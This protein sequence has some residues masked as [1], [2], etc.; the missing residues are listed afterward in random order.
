MSEYNSSGEVTITAEQIIQRHT[1]LALIKSAEQQRIANVI[2]VARLEIEHPSAAARLSAADI[3]YALE[4]RVALSA[5]EFVT[6]VMDSVDAIDESWTSDERI[7]DGLYSARPLFPGH[8]IQ[9]SEESSADHEHVDE[10]DTV[11]IT[12]AQGT[13]ELQRGA[14]RVLIASLQD[15]VSIGVDTVVGR[16]EQYAIQIA[17][18]RLYVLTGDEVVALLVDLKQIFAI[19]DARLKNLDRA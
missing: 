19:R 4:D 14:A 1:V 2:A 18:G 3:Q 6:R 17:T 9:V 7:E 15:L 11:V 16:G 8:S 13:H 10:F 5:D 12:T